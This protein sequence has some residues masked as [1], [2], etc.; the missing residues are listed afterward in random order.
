MVEQL[1]ASGIE[2]S[3]HDE[4]YPNGRFFNQ[5]LVERGYAQVLTIPP[6]V[7]YADRFLA[8]QRKARKAERGLW[9]PGVC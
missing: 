1:R 9:S 8:A 7:D 2:V 4:T 3:V 5:M 6:N